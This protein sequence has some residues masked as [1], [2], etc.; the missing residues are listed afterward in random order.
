[1]SASR[2][3]HDSNALGVDAEH[4]GIVTRPANRSLHILV[5]CRP[6]GLTAQ[7]IL[8]R[9]GYIAACRDRRHLWT[10]GI[11]AAASKSPSMQMYERHA[12]LGPRR[13]PVNIDMKICVSAFADHDV[14]LNFDRR[15]VWRVQRASPSVQRVSKSS[16]TADAEQHPSRDLSFV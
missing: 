7:S 16:S 14:L 4:R 13:R 10:Q 15:R 3:A 2:V 9:D 8:G 11:L 5:L 12:L 6:L 1:M